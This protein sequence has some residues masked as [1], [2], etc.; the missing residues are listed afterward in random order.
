[1][2][3]ETVDPRFARRPALGVVRIT[4]PSS[5]S[6][7]VSRSDRTR[8]PASSTGRTPA[9]L[10]LEAYETRWNRSVDPVYS[11]LAY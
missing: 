6:E 4:F 8:K 1:M 7:D 9:E 3:I 10:L 5:T 2:K 11:E